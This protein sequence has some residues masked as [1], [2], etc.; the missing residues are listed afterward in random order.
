MDN[1]FIIFE[2]SFNSQRFRYL[3]NF[4]QAFYGVFDNTAQKAPAGTEI[5]PNTRDWQT[6]HSLAII[7]I[8]IV[9]VAAFSRLNFTFTE[10]SSAF[11]TKSAFKEWFSFVK[12]WRISVN[13][14][15]E[16]D[17]RSKN[18]ILLNDLLMLQKK[19]CEYVYRYAINHLISFCL[20]VYLNILQPFNGFWILLDELTCFG[21]FD[22]TWLGFL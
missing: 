3:G 9:F 7:L 8:I 10:Q 14:N 18:Y 6:T 16:Y 5:S 19:K 4:W 17:E 1:W 2:S 15:K 22:G 11:C 12:N 13:N 20:S 21:W